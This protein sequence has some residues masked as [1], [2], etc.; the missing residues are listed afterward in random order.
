[1]NLIFNQILIILKSRVISCLIHPPGHTMN[2]SH[3]L[4]DPTSWPLTI[5]HSPFYLHDHAII[6]PP[7]DTTIQSSAQ[8]RFTIPHKY[9]LTRS[10][11]GRSLE[12]RFAA[13]S[14]DT[15]VRSA[16]ASLSG[17]SR[18]GTSK[19]I[20][21]SLA[22]CILRN[23]LTTVRVPTKNCEQALNTHLFQFEF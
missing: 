23:V 17:P 13:V 14:V 11:N 10:L 16:C 19:L 9:Q 3:P 1:M 5:T 7:T 12:E 8:Y 18:T 6:H 22:V 4:T 15:A 21:N 2:V 20:T